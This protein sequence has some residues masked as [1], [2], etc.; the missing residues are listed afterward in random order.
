MARWYS[1][2][3]LA[4]VPGGRRLWHLSA[5]GNRFVVQGEKAF[6]PTE[7][8]PSGMAGK[9]WRNLFRG[10]LNLAWLPASKVF[11]RAVHLPASDP[12]EIVQMVEL[13]L[14]KISP[15]PVMQIVWSVHL[16]PRP[17]AKPD[18]LQTVIVMIAARA[19]LDE[20][21]GQLEASGY[22]ADRLEAPGLD[23]LL[24]ANIHEEGIWIFPAGE[25]EPILAVWWYGGTVQ[26]LTMISLPATPDRGARLKTQIEQITWA[27]EL[28]GWLSG[29]LKIHLV[30]GPKEAHFW[31]EIFKEVGEN[32]T[33]LP[34]V[35]LP[36]LA[37]LSAQR[38]AGS[39]GVGLLPPEFAA[40]YRQ[41]FVDG[42]WMRGLMAVFSAYVVGV[43]IYFGALYAL[44]I[45]YTRVKQQA[46]SLG[47]NYTNALKDFKQIEILQ[48]RQELK[49]KA[50][51]CWKVVAENL[52]E[53]GVVSSMDFHRG[54]LF[55]V[56]TAD[57]SSAIDQFND[58]LR[59]A[60]NP[61]RSNQLL[62]T[63]VEL[64]S[65]QSA[66]SNSVHWSFKCKMKEEAN[67]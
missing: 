46:D 63:E 50:L 28:E 9:S 3:V 11:L 45:K 48:V 33:V 62:F 16:L 17:A 43:L 20:F 26:N 32:V 51:D 12:A 36:Q 14:E 39:P 53:G 61:N 34:P 7:K 41:Q 23:E 30:A 42:L 6:L 59:T 1:A 25:D 27:G 35:A 67:E 19:A 64:P 60:P 4:N 58:A 57:D 47:I 21:L 10:K 54:S 55:L 2:N 24:A 38:C 66:G 29:P 52:P 49:Y 13:Q 31:D 44:K 15:L 37:S 5:T 56:G 8:V 40:R 65:I 18:A 22:Q